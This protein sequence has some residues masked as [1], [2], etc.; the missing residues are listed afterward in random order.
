M[1]LKQAFKYLPT[2]VFCLFIFSFMIMYFVLPK[3]KYSVREKK[4]LSD[5]PAIKSE[6]IFSGELQDKVNDYLADY[7]PGRY[8]FLGLS[9]DYEL[10]VGKNG[11]KGVYLGSDGSLY[12]LPVSR[13]EQLFKNAGFIEEFADECKNEFDIPVYA[14]V[15]PTSGYINENKLPANHEEYLD[16]KLI[17]EFSSKLGDNVTFIDVCDG[18]MKAAGSSQLYYKTD[19]HWTTR[20]AYEGYRLLGEKMGYE[21]LEK[22]AFSVEKISGF[23]GTSYA[24]AALWWLPSE[25]IELWSR[26]DASENAV[27][28]DIKEGKTVN[29]FDSYYFRSHLKE[30][31]KYEVFLDGV[32]GFE[33]IK[34]ADAKGGKLLLVK[35]SYAHSIVPF[36][37][38]NYSEIVMVDLRARK[39]PVIDI[40]EQEEPDEVLILYSLQNISEDDALSFLM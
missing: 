27:S 9:S 25:N 32:K 4:Y 35:D 8:F 2:F 19:H 34:N 40:V 12:P 14:T 18:L 15:L 28:V 16:R 33:R 38:Q 11:S 30:D 22:D 6:E 5:F 23:K 37:S 3:E 13:N 20:G 24:K 1:K 17:G 29:S 21:P 10:A 26:K 39:M 36:L 7:L 31:D